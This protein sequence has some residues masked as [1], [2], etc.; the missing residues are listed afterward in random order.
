MLIHPGT[1]EYSRADCV[2]L[3]FNG[4]FI[5]VRFVCLLWEIGD[6]PWGTKR[7]SI[8]L[9]CDE[10]MGILVALRLV[11]SFIFAKSWPGIVYH[12]RIILKGQICCKLYD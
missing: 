4:A 12:S 9:N 7:S 3:V 5:V 10:Q 6:N 2:V 11:G 8:A 1:S